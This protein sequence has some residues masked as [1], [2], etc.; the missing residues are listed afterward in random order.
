M[1]TIVTM[2]TNVRKKFFGMLMLGALLCVLP[3]FT[4]CSEEETIFNFN[5]KAQRYTTGPDNEVI[6][7]TIASYL[8]EEGIIDRQFSKH[9]EGSVDINSEEVNQLLQATVQEVI[10]RLNDIDY[11]A[12]LRDAGITVTP[13]R[14]E[15]SIYFSVQMVDANGNVWKESPLI[16]TLN[17]DL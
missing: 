9:V 5:V 1:K 2:K 4:S 17:F 12:V 8:R 14:P 7:E 13:G 10:D 6:C 3:V 15:I 16:Y 11:Q